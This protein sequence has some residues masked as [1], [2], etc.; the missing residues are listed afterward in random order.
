MPLVID[1]DGLNSLAMH[2][3]ES[4]S[5]LKNAKRCVLLTPHPLEFARLAGCTVADVQADRIGSLLRFTEENRVTVILKGAGTLIASPDGRLT[6]NPTGSPALSK[7]GSGDTLAGA[8]AALLAQSLEMHDAAS[9]A[10]YLHG[11]AGDR[12]SHEYSEYGVL[13][14]QL[15]AAIGREIRALEIIRDKE[16]QT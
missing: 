2:Q 15:P 13:P 12:L 16:S 7:A 10:V 4:L 9:L 3:S 11:A 5:R 6:L 14:S 8:V 1:A